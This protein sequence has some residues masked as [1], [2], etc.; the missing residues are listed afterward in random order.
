MEVVGGKG[1]DAVAGSG[2]FEVDD[3]SEEIR[4]IRVIPEDSAMSPAVDGSTS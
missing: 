4:S 1:A 3:G 2:G